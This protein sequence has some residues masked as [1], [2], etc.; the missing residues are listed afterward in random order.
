MSAPSV[1][2]SLPDLSLFKLRP[3]PDPKALPPPSDEYTLRS[4]WHISSEAYNFWLQPT[5]P[6]TF[7]AIYATVIIGLNRFNRKNGNQPWRIAKTKGF[8]FFVLAHNIFL[9]LYSAATCAAMVRALRH[10]WP[11]YGGS[12][13][14][15]AEAVDA[16]CKMHGPRGIGDAASYNRT[17]SR[18]AVKNTAIR[19]ASDGIPDSTDVGRLWNEGL[20]FWGWLFYLS[21]FYEVV[22]SFI[23]ILKGKKSSSLQIYHHAGAMTAMW[24]GIRYMSP[25]IW[26]FV[27]V[28]SFIHTWMYGYYTAS[29]LRFRVPIWFKRTLTTCQILQFVV[30]ALFAATHLFVSY[31]VP[32]STPYY[33]FTNMAS[34]A[35]I[36][37]SSIPAAASSAVSSAVPTASAQFASFLKKMAFRAAGQEGLAENVGISLDKIE[38]PIHIE[39]QKILEP[40]ILEPIREI[41]YRNE[42]QKVP[43]IDT[44]GES[45][46]IWVNLIYLFP[47]TWLFLRFFIRSYTNRL[48]KSTSKQQK[49]I[50]ARSRAI[51]GASKD[52]AKGTDREFDRAGEHADRAVKDVSEEVRKD[53]EALRQRKANPE[54][55]DRIPALGEE[56]KAFGDATILGLKERMSKIVPNGSIEDK[57]VQS[58][59]F[60]TESVKDGKEKVF[61]NGSKEGDEVNQSKTHENL[62][63]NSSI[64]NDDKKDDGVNGTSK[65]QQIEEPAEGKPKSAEDSID[66]QPDTQS[67]SEGPIEDTDKENQDPSTSEP[68]GDPQPGSMATS[69]T[70]S[71]LDGSYADV[72]R[73]EAKST[74]ATEDEEKSEP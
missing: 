35:N 48:S 66:E 17:S 26:M 2:L 67:D 34:A 50:T 27:C 72:V 40:K 22:D 30:G 44:S 39:E 74:K 57:V 52:A 51:I 73:G 28:N 68:N 69:Q 12:E 4:P 38:E 19:L 31:S 32:V 53:L 59:Q 1:Y 5:I 54:T 11:S 60:L 46:A 36:A 33:I 3:D 16:L 25:P 29:A 6:L 21:K 37:T 9:M 45:F 62:S 42:Y 23:L 43:C 63:Q 49:P 14:T 20:A 15:F 41:R 7:A 65:S 10:T 47:L 58:E 70:V 56:T 24:A 18:W 71:D 55:K 13:Y 61:T 64:L 8:L